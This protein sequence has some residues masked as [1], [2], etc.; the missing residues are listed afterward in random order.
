MKNLLLA[1]LSLYSFQG[2]FI[3]SFKT[4]AESSRQTGARK[5]C[6][7]VTEKIARLVNRRI[8]EFIDQQTN[9]K[10]SLP[11]LSQTSIDLET[12]LSDLILGLCASELDRGNL[13]HAY[14]LADSAE[15]IKEHSEL[16]WIY[17][18]VLER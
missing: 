13:Q 3:K 17:R 15:R 10:G 6:R 8:P 2:H 11:G 5:S 7:L 9:G 1:Q 16:E 12:K 4:L 18:R 14:D